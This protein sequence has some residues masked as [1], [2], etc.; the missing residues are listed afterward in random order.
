[1]GSLP[2]PDPRSDE[3]L[4]RAINRGDAAAFEALYYRYRD[5]VVRLATRFTGRT[6]DALDVLQETFAYLLRKTPSLRL[7]ARMTTF[8]YPVVKHLSLA[9]RR[10]NCR[11]LG[12][13]LEA[14]VPAPP[15]SDNEGLRSGLG[16]VMAALSPDQREVVLMRFVDDMSLAEIAGALRM[17]IGTVKSKL[18]RALERLQ[19]DPRTRAYFQR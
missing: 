2:P 9:A 12:C 5:W 16:E 14:D 7:T 18:H 1:V 10:R 17:P 3:A 8:L 13:E 19:S 11:S 6:D 4:I 15:P